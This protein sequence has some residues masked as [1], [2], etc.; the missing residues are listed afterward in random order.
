MKAAQ[1]G[2]TEVMRG[3][4]DECGRRLV[5]PKTSGS[6]SSCLEGGLEAVRWRWEDQLRRGDEGLA[7]EQGG[8]SRMA[9]VTHSFTQGIFTLCLNI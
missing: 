3:L 1:E 2:E 6:R 4:S 8:C 7:G 9:P 5:G